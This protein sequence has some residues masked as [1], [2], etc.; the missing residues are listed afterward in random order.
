MR[1]NTKEKKRAGRKPQW[2]RIRERNYSNGTVAYRV[3]AGFFDYDTGGKGAKRYAKQFATLAE[4]EDHAAACREK[5][6]TASV[7]EKFERKN[8][9]VSL[10]NLT[11]RQRGEI[12]EAYR[13]LDGGQRGSLL[14]A[15][16]FWLKH[17]AP[18]NPKTP[19]LSTN[20]C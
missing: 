18:A 15:V 12:L 19:T 11:D 2:P 9:A 8:R 16:D 1:T 13:K 6:A 4:A 5:R 3:D 14:A 7:V 17:A 10:A 20:A